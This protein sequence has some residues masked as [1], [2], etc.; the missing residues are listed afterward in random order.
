MIE[1][2]ISAAKCRNGYI[3]WI[4]ATNNLAS[5]ESYFAAK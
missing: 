3:K 4:K 5:H 2:N 1:H